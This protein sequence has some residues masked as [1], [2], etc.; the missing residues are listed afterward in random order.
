MRLNYITLAS[1][2]VA[3]RRLRMEL[4]GKYIGDYEI[5]EFPVPADVY[6]FTKPYIKNPLLLDSYLLRAKKLDFI[7]D[8]SDPRFSDYVKEMIGMAKAVTVPTS[9]M[10]ELVKQETGVDAVVISDTYEYKESEIKDI[11]DPKV[12]WF[13]HHSNLKYVNVDY[14]IEIV[15]T[16]DVVEKPNKNYTMT[17]WSLDNMKKAF[18]RNNIVIIPTEFQWKSPNRVVESIRQGMTVVASPIDAY[19]EFDIN[20]STDMS[21]NNL[22]QTTP[23]LQK[24]VRDNFNIQVIGE[25]WKQ[26]FNRVSGSTLDAAEG[27]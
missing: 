9:K 26:L 15:T 21:I 1:S 12:M 3:S 10:A 2:T 7:F 16:K 23:E 13:G 4:I 6:V 24:Y 20:F 14:P 8:I 5:T 22:K 11:S 18:D 27:F 25:K 17:P 19:K